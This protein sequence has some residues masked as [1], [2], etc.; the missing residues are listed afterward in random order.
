MCK[1]GNFSIKIN[2][3]KQC[4]RVSP[5]ATCYWKLLKFDVH[6]AKDIKNLSFSSFMVHPCPAHTT[7]VVL[8]HIDIELKVRRLFGGRGNSF[9]Y[10][11]LVTIFIWSVLPTYLSV[12][13]VIKDTNR[14]IRTTFFKHYCV[15]ILVPNS[16]QG[17]HSSTFW[18]RFTSPQTSPVLSVLLL[19]PFLESQINIMNPAFLIFLL[20]SIF[21]C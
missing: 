18:V 5:E 19:E 15:W 12:V 17:M 6:G 1:K 14:K 11:N 2:L 4:L 13:V 7:I 3:V 20:N 10:I 8:L 9:F 21:S 16:L